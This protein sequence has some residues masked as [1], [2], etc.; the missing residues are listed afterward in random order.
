MFGPEGLGFQRINI[1]C[2]RDTLHLA[3]TQLKNAV[4]ELQ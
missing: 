3:L 4:A 2:P 1:A